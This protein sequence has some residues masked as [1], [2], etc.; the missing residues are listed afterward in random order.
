MTSTT[1]TYYIHNMLRKLLG[2]DRI[3]QNCS[4]LVRNTFSY[5]KNKKEFPEFSFFTFFHFSP[6]LT[7]EKYFSTHS[8]D[9]EKKGKK[10]GGSNEIS[11]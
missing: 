2:V 7:F 11:M 1:K 8:K 6:H 5:Q 9:D 10:K 4:F 3:S